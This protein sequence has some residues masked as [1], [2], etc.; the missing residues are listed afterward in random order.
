MNVSFPM[1]VSLHKWL[2]VCK[3]FLRTCLRDDLTDVF[4]KVTVSE[5]KEVGTI[6]ANYRVEMNE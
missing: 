6:L 3:M 2:L 5:V 1:N 4:R